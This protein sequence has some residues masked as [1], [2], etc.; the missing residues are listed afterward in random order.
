MKRNVLITIASLLVTGH[1]LP[2]TILIAETVDASE[3]QR[4]EDQSS[5]LDSDEHQFFEPVDAEDHAADESEGNLD[6]LDSGLDE[7][8]IDPELSTIPDRTEESK[9]IQPS[10]H[11]GYSDETVLTAEAV[12]QKIGL[13]GKFVEERLNELVTNVRLNGDEVADED[14]KV[15]LLN[16]P[17]TTFLG[18]LQVPI[19]VVHVE[20]Q[21][22]TQIN[23]PVEVI[24]GHSIFSREAAISASTGV[25]SLHINDN[26]PSLVA[27]EGF[28]NSWPNQVTSR[29]RYTIYRNDYT[30]QTLLPF[31]TVNQSRS[32]VVQAWNNVLN[33]SP[34]D[35]GDVIGLSV[36]RFAVANQNYNGANTWVTRNEE[37]VREAIGWPEALYMMT[38][39]GFQLLRVNQLTTNKLTFAA[40]GSTEEILQR[41]TE[42]FNFHEEFTEQEKEELSFDLIRSDALLPGKEGKAVVQV[43]QTKENGYRFSMT[44]EVSFAV[45][46]GRLELAGIAHGNFDFGDVLKTSRRQNIPAQGE[47]APTIMVSDYSDTAQ[48][49]LY[50]S[51]SPFINERNQELREAAIALKELKVI[52]S[53]HT[54]IS[55]PKNDILLGTTPQMI[56][57]RDGSETRD[58]YGR[59][60]IQ[61]GEVKDQTLTGVS[62]HLPANTP[63]DKGEYQATITWELVGDPT[64]GGIR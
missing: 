5:T 60:I 14:F 7:E 18:N 39:S 3:R 9:T 44:Y 61:I 10:E 62:L 27:S 63:V 30:N 51:M 15:T 37:P 45:G 17:N 52:E 19:T 13:G 48:W 6:L 58:E 8:N 49:S 11:S 31:F 1:L 36:N 23:V 54:G 64:I 26:G 47:S 24:W 35:F 33:N 34:I 29:P 56:E 38:S 43:T 59:T 28:G 2:S 32:S 21:A 25:I 41:M 20:T 4:A 46:L 40:S 50:A 16:Q 53:V 42:F 12:P 55:I 22:A 57:A